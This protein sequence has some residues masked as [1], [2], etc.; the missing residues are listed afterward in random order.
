[1]TAHALFASGGSR[2]GTW[3]F[4]QAIHQFTEVAKHILL[5]F[6]SGERVK[7][8]RLV[9]HPHTHQALLRK[10]DEVLSDV[11]FSLET[12]HGDWKV[13]ALEG[14]KLLVQLTDPFRHPFVILLQRREG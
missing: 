10:H 2:C 7:V 4:L 1:M 5:L 3:L 13:A 8:L 11:A 14:W 9:N 12:L 6:R